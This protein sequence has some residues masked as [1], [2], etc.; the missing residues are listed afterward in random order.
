MKV[1]KW[2]IS[3]ALVN[4]ALA[5]VM[6]RIGLHE[7][8]SDHRQ[9]PGYFYHGNLYYLPAAQIATYCWNMPAYVASS[10]FAEI[11]IRYLKSDS[12]AF[13]KYSF[14]FVYWGFFVAVALFWWWTGWQLDRLHEPR[15]RVDA[16]PD[17]YFRMA[18]YAIV[19]IFAFA[20]AYNGFVFR[21]GELV[22]RPIPI[23]KMV[24]GM[25]LGAYFVTLCCRALVPLV[26]R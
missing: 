21:S 14:F 7:Y 26:R 25:G 17:G 20:M 24:W 19:A 15:R 10:Q 8:L 5:L 6:C 13:S 1:F 23:A 11:G 3:L 4:L 18:F 2:R 9:H 16:K 12:P 22:A